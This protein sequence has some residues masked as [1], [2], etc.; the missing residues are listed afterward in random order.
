MSGRPSVKC[1][2][3]RSR[4]LNYGNLKKK[5]KMKVKLKKIL[6]DLQNIPLQLKLLS[7]GLKQ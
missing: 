1:K 2:E 7:P 5:V 6:Y 4:K 3:M